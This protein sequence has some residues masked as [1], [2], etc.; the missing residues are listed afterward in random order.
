MKAPPSSRQR[1]VRK[2]GCLVLP[3]ALLLFSC[4]TTQKQLNALNETV[5][6]TMKMAHPAL[7]KNEAAAIDACKRAGTMKPPAIPS[8]D[9]WAEQCPGFKKLWGPHKMLTQVA[10]GIHAAVGAAGLAILVGNEKGA[11]AI[12]TKLLTSAVPRLQELLGQSGLL[13]FLGI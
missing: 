7:E 6:A 2:R 12:L 3:T 11:K 5:S 13:N 8:L 9:T 10:Q 4:A 1:W